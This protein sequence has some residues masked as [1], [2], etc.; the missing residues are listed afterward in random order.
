[1][2]AFSSGMP[3]TAPV[4]RSDAAMNGLRPIIGSRLAA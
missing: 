2:R 4:A 3:E 1:V